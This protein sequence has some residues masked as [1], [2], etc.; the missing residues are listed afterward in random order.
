VQ[1]GILA[2]F[3]E[4]LT[5]RAQQVQIGDGFQDGVEMG[6]LIDVAGLEKVERHVSDIVDLG[7][8][9]LT[10]GRR[11]ELGHTFY[12]PTVITDVSTD[13][14]PW[15]DEET[16][17]PIAAITPFDDEDEALRLANATEY[18]LV[19]YVYTHDVGRV[20]RV[21]EALETGMVA[22]N[23]GRVSNE[24]AP[25]GGIKQSGIGREGS[26]YG[27]EDWLSLKYINLAGLS[28]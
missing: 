3:T 21:S 13:A 4:A 23:T 28:R 20:F 1:R 10:G 8:K 2:D 26:K 11:S 12:E 19:A 15:H 22:V 17:G 24:A 6:P 27:I 25:F 16:F 9:V 14:L 7:G 18:G 5:R